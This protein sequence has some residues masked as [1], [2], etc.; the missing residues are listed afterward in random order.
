M[1]ELIAERYLA[2][3]YAPDAVAAETG[4]PADTIRRI[5]AELAEA[6]FEQTITL[7][8]PGPTGPAASTTR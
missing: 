1:F 7:P 2:D 3:E 6:A 5:A 8:I 4:V